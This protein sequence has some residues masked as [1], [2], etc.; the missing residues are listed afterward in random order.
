MFTYERRKKHEAVRLEFLRSVDTQEVTPD[1]VKRK[2]L[3][4]RMLLYNQLERNALEA[5][6]APAHSVAA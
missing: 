6:A 3:A 5:R 4:E 1:T 2:E